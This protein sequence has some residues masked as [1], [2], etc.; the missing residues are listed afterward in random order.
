MPDEKQQGR[1]LSIPLRVRVRATNSAPGYA[2]N[3]ER[4]Q[5]ARQVQ[6]LNDTLVELTDL[7]ARMNLLALNAAIEAVRAGEHGQR[8]VV[9]AQEMRALAV[10]SAEAARTAVSRLRAIHG[11]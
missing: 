6:E 7:A 2:R 5:Q 10:H 4:P 8:F 3:G 9:I 11:E 1:V